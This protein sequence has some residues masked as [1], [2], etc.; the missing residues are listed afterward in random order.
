MGKHTIGTFSDAVMT[1]STEER[2]SE[3]ETKLL[4]VTQELHDVTQRL[5]NIENKRKSK[6]AFVPKYQPCESSNQTMNDH[7]GRHGFSKLT[8]QRIESL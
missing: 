6:S 5:E 2:L 8:L 4:N 3:L 1:S 7:I